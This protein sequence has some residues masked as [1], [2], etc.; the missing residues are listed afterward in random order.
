[1]SLLIYEKE[2]FGPSRGVERR[3]KFICGVGDIVINRSHDVLGKSFSHVI[4]VLKVFINDIWKGD[5]VKFFP[6]VFLVCSA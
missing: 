1:M 5:V 2:F 3:D 4:K 6:K